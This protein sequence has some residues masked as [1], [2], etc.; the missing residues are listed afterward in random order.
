[1]VSLDPYVSERDVPL[2]Q[3]SIDAY[4]PPE[5]H[6]KM[7]KELK[8]LREEGVLLLGSGN[9]VHNLRLVDWHQKNKGFDWAYEFD[10]YIYENILNNNHEDIINCDELGM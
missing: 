1:M 7:G 2:F 3:I 4:A 10:D 9:I 6:Y 8:A 5:T